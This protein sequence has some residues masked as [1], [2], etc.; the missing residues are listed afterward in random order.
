[1]MIVTTE[2]VAGYAIC[3]VLG[4]VVATTARA[5]NPFTEGVRQL[6]QRQAAE[7]HD[8]LNQGRLEA[9]EQLTRQAELRGANA[10]VGMLFDHRPVTH[11]WTE[12]CA[13]GTAVVLEPV[14][15]DAREQYALM[16]TQAL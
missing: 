7:L 9:L 4:T 10:V 6:G 15:A 12:I 2:D 3:A 13:Y 14:S 16:M 1:M 5:G 8:A 11:Y